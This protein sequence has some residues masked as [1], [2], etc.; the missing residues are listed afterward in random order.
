MRD[1]LA[2]GG[3]NRLGSSNVLGCPADEDRE[4][5]FLGA[6]RATGDR[7]VDV[8][9]TVLAQPFGGRLLRGGR[10]RRAIDD[11]AAAAQS[12]GDAVGPEEGGLD[13]G[14]VRDAHD[15][16]IGV[17]RKIARRPGLGR[18]PGDE[19]RRLARCAV[20]D[21]QRET[22]AG[23]VGSHRRAHGPET[24]ETDSLHAAPFRRRG[25]C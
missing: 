1:R 6:F 18:A 12:L 19:I 17:S 20:P 4:R 3:Q 16:H 9:H 24:H 2:H 8:P 5:P 11:E 22:G 15:D 21:R 10:D 23:Q 13:I 14:R 25:G 7:G